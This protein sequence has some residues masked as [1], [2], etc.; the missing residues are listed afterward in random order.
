MESH[1]DQQQR[2]PGGTRAVE[3]A[4]AL[5]EAVAEAP[6]GLRLSTAARLAGVPTSTGLRLL[7]TLE[8]AGHVRRDDRGRYA[9]GPR[10]FALGGALDRL[11]LLELAEP[12]LRALVDAAGETANLA[13]PDGQGDV[14]YLSQVQAPHAVRYASWRGRR[15]PGDVS[16]VGAAL[17]GETGE[18]GFVVRRDAVETGVTAI[19][20]PVYDAR[21]RIVAALSVS[22]PSYRVDERAT[23]RIGRQVAR[24]ALDLSGDLGAAGPGTP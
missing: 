21:L 8:R 17:R 7:R 3:R 4:L 14:V 18:H 22:A 6:E 20:A 19:A 9:A 13:V 5:L 12:H 2:V 16:A 15:V 23:D 11:P 10:L 1:A 24:A